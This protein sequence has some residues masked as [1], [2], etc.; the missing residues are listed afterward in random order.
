M[1]ENERGKAEE[2]GG[3]AEVERVERADRFLKI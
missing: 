2:G 3:R 1:R